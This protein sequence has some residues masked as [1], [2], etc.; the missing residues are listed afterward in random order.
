V[1]TLLTLALTAVAFGLAY[2]LPRKARAGH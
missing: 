1:T 2:L